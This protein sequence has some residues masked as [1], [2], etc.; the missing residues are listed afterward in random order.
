MK[1]KKARHAGIE[2]QS[3]KAMLIMILQAIINDVSI[4]L[5]S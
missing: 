4:M 3:C 5:T 2:F 1:C